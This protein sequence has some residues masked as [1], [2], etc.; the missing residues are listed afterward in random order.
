[1][2]L[3]MASVGKGRE[4]KGE[5]WSSPSF[6]LSVDHE[7]EIICIF[8][9]HFVLYV[10]IRITALLIIIIMGDANLVEYI[11]GNKNNKF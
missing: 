4:G 10:V 6:V 8:D 3:R 7:D 5:E 11:V 9:H 2:T 1:M